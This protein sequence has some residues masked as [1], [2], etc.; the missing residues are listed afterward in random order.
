MQALEL[1]KVNIILRLAFDAWGKGFKVILF[2]N[3]HSVLDLLES[4]LKPLGVMRIDGKVSKQEIANRIAK[5]QEPNN[6]HQVL[7]CNLASASTGISLHDTTG[8]FPRASFILPNYAAINQ[9]QATGRTFRSGSV[10]TAY[11]RF[12]YG[13]AG[14]LERKIMTS[15]SKKSD[16]M[17]QAIGAKVSGF[18]DYPVFF[19]ERD[20][21]KPDVFTQFGKSKK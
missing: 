1:T 10:G 19:E 7:I 13:T 16:V 18:A 17:E 2:A 6:K 11:V 8:K 3:Y 15:L 12:V 20:N 4:E 9:L 14:I 5:F 21:G